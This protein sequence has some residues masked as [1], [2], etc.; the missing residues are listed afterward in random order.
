MI[1]PS[2]GHLPKRPVPKAKLKYNT[3]GFSKKEN[4][5][6]LNVNERYTETL[7]AATNMALAEET[8]AQY[9]TAIRHIERAAQILNTDMSLPFNITKTL[10]YVGYLLEDR[11]VSSKTVSQ[12]LSAVRMLHLCQGFETEFLRPQIVSLILKGRE[13]YENAID[14]IHKKPK[15]V[16]VTINVLKFMKRKLSESNFTTEKKLRLWSICCLMW[17]GSL[18]VHEVLSKNKTEFD[19]LITLCTEDI[20]IIETKVDNQDKSL[21]RL[22]LKSPKE[23]R[24]GKGVKLEIFEN[25]TFCCPV[26]AWKKWK[27]KVN[28]EED[29]P[30]F[31][32]GNS[33]FT[34]SEFNKILSN[35][36][37]EI[38]DGTDGIIRSHS[39]RSGVAS[40]MGLRGF[41]DTEIQAQGRSGSEY[42]TFIFIYLLLMGKIKEGNK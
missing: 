42:S 16:A 15:R 27:S 13:H 30:I 24:I 22:H 21:I 4:F 26:K 36:T 19:P 11:K 3:E 31:R 8:K 35:L 20:E 39:F 1:S 2:S 29:L 41:S 33:C 5:I 37:K 25:K 28:L 34:G 9:R 32:E 14:T 40:E 12:Y 17:N 18:R 6:K 7:A 23:N 10:N 38:T